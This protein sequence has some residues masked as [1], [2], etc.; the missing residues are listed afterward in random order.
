MKLDFYIWVCTDDKT[1]VKKHRSN[2]D[3]DIVLVYNPN[4][5]GWVPNFVN[6]EMHDCY[7]SYNSNYYINPTDL[8]FAMD[9]IDKFV[10]KFS[11]LLVFL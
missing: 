6:K 1:Y 7:C 3:Y 10:I 8:D 9:Y 2:W 4:G 11:K 5:Y